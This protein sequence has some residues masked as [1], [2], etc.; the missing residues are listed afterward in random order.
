[1][2]LR[3]DA[4]LHGIL[5]DGKLEVKCDSRFCGHAPGVV[6]LHTYDITTGELI[7]TVRYKNPRMREKETS[8]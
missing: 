3:C 5:K 7:S 8:G 2:E 4:K 6:V 1:M